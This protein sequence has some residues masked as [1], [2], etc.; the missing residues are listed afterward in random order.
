MSDAEPWIAVAEL[1]LE[2]D[3]TALSQ[4]LAE[5]DVAHRFDDRPGSR[6]LLVERREDIPTVLMLLREYSRLPGAPA[7][8][9]AVQARQVPVV[10]VMLLLGLIGALLVSFLPD[11]IHWFTFQDFGVTDADKLSLEPADT[12]FSRREYWR[13]LT[14]A[15]LHFGLFHIVFNSLWIWEFGRR[16]EP[17]AGHANFLLIFLAI[18]A[19]ANVGQYLWHPNDLFGGLSGVVYGLLGYIWVR[20][21]LAP[22]P[23][24][25]LAPGI[26]PLMIIWLLVC[27]AGVVDLFLQ[28]GVA[29]GAHV[30]GLII[31]A[32]FGGLAGFSAR[33][34]SPTE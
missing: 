30:T 9:L 12:A 3:V 23:L 17:L 13:L 14:P 5:R 4:R 26:F 10:V 20:N 1:P 24:L 19:G 28:G 34:Q 29:N 6:V 15:F 16:V 11:A 2:I 8:S 32:L 33:A 27:L 31:G 18:A 25:G 22:H 21:K 7:P